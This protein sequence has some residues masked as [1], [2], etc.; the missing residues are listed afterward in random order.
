MKI[1]FFSDSY[2]PYLSGVVKSID[3]FASQLKKEG[4]EVYIF[5]PNYPEAEAGDNIY[6]FKSIPALTNQGF[7][8][9][10]PFSARV[11]QE[12]KEIGLDIIHTHS[13]F[14]MGWLA[15]HIANRLDIP[16]VFTYHTL[17]EKYAH[18][19]PVGQKLAGKLVVKYSRD[20]C[21][22]CDLVI[23]PSRFVEELLQKKYQVTT[24][25]KT[26]STGLDLKPYHKGNGSWVR[27]KYGIAEDKK[28][29][30]FVG[31]LGLEKN[32]TFLLK[33][34]RKISDSLAGVHLIMV[35]DGPERKNLEELRE[36]LALNERIIFAGFQNP[37]KV[38]DFYLAS[39]MF[40]FPSMS[41][42]QG[43]VTLEAMAGGLPVVAVN[44]AG[45]T[46]MIEDGLDGVLV[47]P[48]QHFFARAV[49]ELINHRV[50]YQLFVKNALKKAERYSI[51]NMTL[52]LI[53]GYEELLFADKYRQDLA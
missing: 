7:R 21:Q 37:E 5:A 16:L 30:L 14:L 10:L 1:G 23:T 18:Y 35:G 27:E 13:P 24:P 36:K 31:R 39:D 33:A 41:E 40:V 42:T 43:L 8:I 47:K 6:R 26:V 34:F 48:D 22:S 51:D 4:H 32:L 20:Y 49:L 11:V 19:A 52:K 2:K 25:V 44:A 9:A 46:D 53:N 28:I 15:R 45:S 38:I 17:Y 29:L 50:R 3:L 12:V